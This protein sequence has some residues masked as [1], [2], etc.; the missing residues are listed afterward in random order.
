MTEKKNYYEIL[1]VPKNASKDVIARAMT[2]NA[3]IVK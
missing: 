1:G 2:A 3:E